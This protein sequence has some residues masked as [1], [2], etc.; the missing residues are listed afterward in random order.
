MANPKQW[1]RSYRLWNCLYELPFYAT[2]A[3]GYANKCGVYI[4]PNGLRE[5]ER[6]EGGG[7]EKVVSNIHL[8][9]AFY[10]SLADKPAEKD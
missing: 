5:E 7:P 8:G 3:P 4:T 6:N 1:S 9:G 10:S 2:Q